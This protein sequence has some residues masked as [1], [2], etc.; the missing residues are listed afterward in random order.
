MIILEKKI[1][2]KNE[3]FRLVENHQITPEQGVLLIKKLK[4]KK[5]FQPQLTTNLSYYRP[6]WNKTAGN[7]MEVNELEKSLPL[8]DNLLL[9]AD[10]PSL[11]N[12]WQEEFQ[13]AIKVCLEDRYEKK[14][15]S[16]Y[17]INFKK[18]QDYFDLLGDLKQQNLF[19]QSIF[20]FLGNESGGFDLEKRDDQIDRHFFFFTIPLS[21]IAGTKC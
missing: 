9:L 15:V 16:H 6:V 10:N 11:L 17:T 14:S 2:D 20:Y 8:K 7:S 21:S 13:E 19:P 5:S 18:Q 12:S 3:V 4:K 1:V